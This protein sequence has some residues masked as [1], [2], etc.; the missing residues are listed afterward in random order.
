MPTNDRTCSVIPSLL[1]ASNESSPLTPCNGD[2]F[3]SQVVVDSIVDKTT[4]HMARAG[5]EPPAGRLTVEEILDG[6]LTHQGFALTGVQSQ[7]V[8]NA[9]REMVRAVGEERSG[10]QSQDAKSPSSRRRTSDSSARG[11]AVTASTPDSCRQSGRSQCGPLSWLTRHRRGRVVAF[12]HVLHAGACAHSH[13]LTRRSRHTGERGVR[14][15]VKVPCDVPNPVADCQSSTLQPQHCCRRQQL[16]RQQLQRQTQAA[17]GCWL[18]N[19]HST[20]GCSSEA[21]PQA[22]PARVGNRAD[23]PAYL[24]PAT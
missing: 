6:I 14:C 21:H 4:E 19:W 24:R 7:A 11:S 8:D 12:F 16:R 5:L 18:Q 1:D 9:V 22:A 10:R 20:A 3:A 17:W 23:Q 2:L 13:W 15:G